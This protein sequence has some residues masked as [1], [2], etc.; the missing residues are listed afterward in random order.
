[1]LVRRTDGRVLGKGFYHPNSL[2]AVRL[3]GDEH[4]EIGFGFFREKI[5]YALG[6]REKY[7]RSSKVYRVVHG[8]SDGLP[9][10]IIDRYGSVIV[11]QTLSAGMDKYKTLICDVIESVFSPAA[12]IEKNESHLRTLENLP[13]Q[14]SV[15]RGAL[16]HP[17]MLLEINDLMVEIDVLGGQKTGWF[18]DQ[19]LNHTL[20]RSI[21]GSANVLDC[22]AYHGGFGLQAAHAG[23]RKVTAVDISAEAVRMCMQNARHNKF[24]GI[25]NAIPGEVPGILERYISA[26]ERFDLVIVDPPSFT[27]SKKNVP[28][29]LKAYRSLHESALRLIPPGGYLASA[30]C[31]YH[32]FSEVFEGTVTAAADRTDRKIQIIQRAGASPDHPVLPTMPETEYLKFVLYRV[33]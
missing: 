17:P 23:A 6:H 9:G 2:I 4:T 26:K 27:R 25:F 29:A 5:E 33:L 1:M 18:L 16:P 31:S 15:L 7:F 20:I 11:I 10:L 14:T 3:L 19:R 32:I 12:I 28:T 21:A 13:Q 8:E 22:Y 30:C 24:E